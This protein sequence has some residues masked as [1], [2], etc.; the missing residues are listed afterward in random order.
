MFNP[1][2]K[3]VVHSK[4][5]HKNIYVQHIKGVRVIT[6]PKCKR[7][8]KPKRVCFCLLKSAIDICRER[9]NHEARSWSGTTRSLY[10]RWSFPFPLFL[11]SSSSCLSYLLKLGF[12][13]SLF[14][15]FRIWL[16]F[17]SNDFPFVWLISTG[18]SFWFCFLHR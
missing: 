2:F 7:N 14:N 15:P 16:R 13:F 10:L 9:R 1:F 5:Y 3:F 8:Q 6:N 11:P 4:I 12:V 18:R 17:R